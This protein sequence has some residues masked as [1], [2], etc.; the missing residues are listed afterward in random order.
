MDG[1][2][3]KPGW[4]WIFI[5]EGLFTVVIGL[6]GFF[7]VPSTPRDSKFLTHEQKLLI[8]ARLEADRPS[9]RPSDKFSIGEIVKSLTS[10][11]VLVVFVIFFMIGTNLYGLA[12][13]IP[14]IIKQLGFDA[15][16]TQLLSVGPFAGGFFVTV[17]SAMLSDK[18]HSRGITNAIISL[19][20][21]AGYALYLAGNGKH[22]AYAA[23]YLIVPG[24][25]ATPPVVAAWMANNSEP[26]YRRATSVAFGFI[27]TNSVRDLFFIYDDVNRRRIHFNN[28]SRFSITV[29]KLTCTF[30]RV[31]S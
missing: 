24:V 11:H 31:A 17:F 9:I 19:L 25:Y 27:A 3:N 16:K 14:S 20:A 18:Y 21:V 8:M 15:N 2:G 5:I 10:P 28:G 7:L 30:T 4:A 23:L 12:L 26:Y 22:T 29:N 13:F 1:I 6:A